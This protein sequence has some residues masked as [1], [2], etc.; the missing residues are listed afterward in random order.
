MTPFDGVRE[1][2]GVFGVWA[3]GEDVAR[4]TYFGL[5]ALQH[6]G[7]ESAGIATSDGS[8][9]VVYRD[10]GLVSQVFNEKVLQGLVGHLAIGHV[11]YSTTGSSHRWE[12]AQPARVSRADGGDIALGH[13]GNLVNTSEIAS[14]L[15]AAGVNVEASTDS[16]LIAALLAREPSDDLVDSFKKVA[17]RLQGA[18]SI[19]AMD[20]NRI[21]GMR[22][23]FGV[24]P[25]VIGVLPGGGY[26]FASETC[27]L[28]IVGAQYIRDVEPGELVVIDGAGVHSHCLTEATPR[29]CVFEFVYLARPDSVLY[30]RSVYEVRR[31]MGKQLADESPVEADLVIGVPD[32]G[33]AAAQGFAD[34]A[35]LPYGEGLIKNRYVGRT[36]IQ[37]TQSL[38]QQGVRLKLNPLQEVIEGKRL[39]VVDDSIVRGT[40]SREIVEMLRKAGAR[41]VHM[42]ISSP[43]VAWPCFYGIDTANRDELIAANASPNEIR[44]FIGA[45]SLGY[46]SLD[47][48]LTSTGVATERFCHACFSGGYPIPVPTETLLTKNV[49]EQA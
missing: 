20:E 12:N 17:P 44:G 34:R 19:V 22:D 45:D 33:H 31:S 24:R 4:L 36:F 37:P 49:L 35:G 28:D 11:R 16:H 10:L 47:G 40:T 3:P 6:R 9:V 27:A 48:M 1:E 26:V 14:E 29:L 30:G 7:Q 8:G 39:V 41:E 43:P 38:R 21:Y 2:C 13:N 23:P 18:F 46:L 5:Y 42:R 32:S 25:L 15:A